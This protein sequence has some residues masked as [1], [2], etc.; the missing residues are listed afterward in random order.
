MKAKKVS[1]YH[2]HQLKFWY[3]I[4]SKNI[5]I[6]VQGFEVGEHVSLGPLDC[7]AGECE[8]PDNLVEA[9]EEFIKAKKNFREK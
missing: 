1:L 5:V 6:A 3:F 4:P 9:A 8:V 7:E 2:P